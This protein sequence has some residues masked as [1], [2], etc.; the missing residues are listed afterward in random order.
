[1]GGGGL[2]LHALCHKTSIFMADNDVTEKHWC[3]EQQRGGVSLICVLH[4]DSTSTRVT[5]DSPD[6]VTSL[7]ISGWR[8]DGVNNVNDANEL[9]W[10]FHATFF[11]NDIF[12]LWDASIKQNSLHN[13]LFLFEKGDAALDSFCPVLGC[14]GSESCWPTSQSRL[15]QV[16]AVN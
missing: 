9:L 12:P 6:E 2:L 5:R 8:F 7:H 15:H 16:N 13:F 11:K 1:M 4:L 14:L 10:A 3:C